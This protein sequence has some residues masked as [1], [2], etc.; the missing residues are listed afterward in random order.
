MCGFYGVYE[1]SRDH[2]VF[3]GPCGG[4]I[5]DRV[6][7]VVLRAQVMKDHRHWI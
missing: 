5:I 6:L 7:V 2:A 4:T 3:T 1:L